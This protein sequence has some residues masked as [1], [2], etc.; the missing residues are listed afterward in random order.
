MELDAIKEVK[1]SEGRGRT[2]NVIT[3][4]QGA[5]EAKYKAS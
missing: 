4:W 5:G 1:V 3:E 2:R